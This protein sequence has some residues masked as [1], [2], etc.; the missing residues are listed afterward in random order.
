MKRIHRSALQNC[1]HTFFALLA[2]FAEGALLT[3]ELVV[4]GEQ[5]H[6][7]ELVD[8]GQDGALVPNRLVP[9]H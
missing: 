3:A 9:R 6:G 4:A 7:G 8:A 2:V 5:F 1:L